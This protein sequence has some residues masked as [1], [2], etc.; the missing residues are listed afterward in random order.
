MH[1]LGGSL[2]CF[3]GELPKS[4]VFNLSVGIWFGRV[5]TSENLPVQNDHACQLFVLPYTEGYKS[6]IYIDVEEG[7]IFTNRASVAGSWKQV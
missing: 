7:N 2:L 6:L 5:S 3:R 1:L 4:N